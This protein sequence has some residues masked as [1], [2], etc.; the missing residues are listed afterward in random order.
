MKNLQKGENISLE[1]VGITSGKIFSG[2]SWVTKNNQ[3]IDIDVSAFLL[4]SKGKVS[5]DGDFIFYNQPESLCKSFIL[6]SEP[7]NGNDLRLFAINKEK[8]PKYVEKIIFVATI[9]NAIENKQNFNCLSDFSIRI[10]ELDAFNGKMINFKLT[11][12][13]KETSMILGELYLYQSKWKFRALGTGFESGL[14]QLAKTYGVDLLGN[15]ASLKENQIAF[16]LENS[17][18]FIDQTM[19]EN[20]IRINKQIKKF[21]PKIKGAIKQQLNE[22][23]TRM[24]LDK[25]FIDIFGY[26]VFS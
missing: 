11:N 23:N 25:V 24:L 2:I 19:I 12:A 17:D 10:F 7:N 6:N 20:E 4:D 9:D 18:K 14:A 26:I 8:L 13:D 16:S 22:S 5:G 15:D 21:L 3:H 1:Q